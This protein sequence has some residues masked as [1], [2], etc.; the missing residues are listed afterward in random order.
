MGRPTSERYIGA[1]EKSA[2]EGGGERTKS[3]EGQREESN[4]QEGATS[5][6]TEGIGTTSRSSRSNRREEEGNNTPNYWG[7][8]CRWKASKKELLAGSKKN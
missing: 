5:P 4:Y 1:R 8:R 6:N 3:F 7:K 2:R